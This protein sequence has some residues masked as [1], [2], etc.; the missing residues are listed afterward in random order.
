MQVEVPF[1][2]TTIQAELPDDTFVIPPGGTSTQFEPIDDLAGAVNDALADPLGSPPIRDLVKP[3][4]KV[5]IAFDDPTAP[6][7]SPLR[8]IAIEGV[9]KELESAGVDRGSVTLICA[10]ALHRKFPHEE[11]A[12]VIGDDLV[13]EFGDR[14]VCHDA[15]DRDNLVY[16]GETEAG[17]DVEVNRHVVDSDLFIYITSYHGRGFS[18]GWK[19]VCVGLSTWRSIRHHHTPDGMSMSVQDNR[20]HKMLDDMGAHLESKI[21]TPIFKIDAI[22]VNPF[23]TSK[24][25]AGSVWAC[26]EAVLGVLEAQ[27]PPRRSLSSDKYDVVVYGVPDWSPYAIF[28]HMNPILTL[29]SSGLGYLGG[30]IQALGKPG[31]TVI[32]ATPCPERWDRVHHASYPDVWENVLTKTRDP[33]QIEREYTDVYISNEVYI[34]KYRNH[35]AFHPVHGIL[36]T[37]PLRRLKHAG[38]IIVAGIEDPSLATHLGYE[39][40]NSIEQ[41]LQMAEE[42]H[43]KGYSVTYAQHPAPYTTKVSM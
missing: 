40:S 29:I 21:D 24:I 26:R 41:A 11:L 8:G 36:A 30:T 4:A 28:S 39:A 22:E 13:K 18:G 1:G 3:G 31:C 5:A 34:E 19:S 27:F 16:F 43:G 32:M 14:L 7:F 42:T 9:L 6:C 23:Q 10:N 17:Y 33:Y 20:M 35:F 15:E 37:H 2:E 38:R 25:F 12:A